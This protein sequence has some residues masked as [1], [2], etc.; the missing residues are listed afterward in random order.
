MFQSKEGFSRLKSLNI[1]VGTI[2]VVLATVAVIDSALVANA[3]LV[4][5]GVSLLILGIARLT[6][7]IYWEEQTPLGKKLRIFTGSIIIPLAITIIATA[8]IIS[9]TILLILLAAALILNGIV[10]I[11][12]AIIN[13]DFPNWFRI[14]FIVIGLITIAF[15]IVT[16]IYAHYGYFTIIILL[17]LIFIFSGFA[18]IM[19]VALTKP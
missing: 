17:S 8:Y 19:F 13:K 16:I 9:S 10:R 5:F 15:S 2:F 12:I 3:I 7:G 18:R 14:S 4:I 11:I 1:A 6:I